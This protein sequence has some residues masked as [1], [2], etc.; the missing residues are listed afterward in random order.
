MRRFEA[1]DG[2]SLAYLDEGEGLPILCLAGLT[3]DRRDF[4]Y[5]APHLTGLRLVRLDARGRGAS[6]WADPDTYTVQQEAEDAVTLLDHLGIERAGIIGTS[7][8]GLLSM[9]LAATAKGRLRG[10]CLVDIGPEI[11]EEGLRVIRGYVGRRPKVR[12]L[13]EAAELRAQIMDGFE[14][15]PPER[16]RAEVEHFFEV[17]EDGLHLAYDPALAGTVAASSGQPSPDLWPLFDGLGGLPLAMIRGANSDLL[18]PQTFAEMRRRRP[19]AIAAEVPGRG[20]VPFLDEPE[21]LAAIRDWIA[22]L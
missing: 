3:R 11:A 16:W 17:R 9:W 8:G 18:T 6:D 4:D 21:S 7:R 14:D 10:V 22:R 15:V 13:A 2:T 1:E 19:D 20:H 5:L 12:T